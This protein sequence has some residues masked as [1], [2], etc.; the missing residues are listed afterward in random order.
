LAL[1]IWAFVFSTSFHSKFGMVDGVPDIE[2]M[3][4]RCITCLV[5]KQHKEATDMGARRA[6]EL[7]HVNV[8]QK[9]HH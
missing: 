9:E 5:G 6:L 7:V 1:K 8:A 2:K 4:G 3:E